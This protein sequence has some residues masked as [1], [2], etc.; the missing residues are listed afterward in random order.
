[1]RMSTCACGQIVCA[2]AHTWRL[3]LDRVP[4]SIGCHLPLLRQGLSLVLE[5]GISAKM[6][7]EPLGATCSAYIYEGILEYNS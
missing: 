4:C 2:R 7:S 3:G 6:A 1:M 5:L